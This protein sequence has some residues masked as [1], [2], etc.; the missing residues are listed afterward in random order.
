M[1]E[2]IPTTKESYLQKA[3]QTK[4]ITLT[5]GN[6]FEIRK[7]NSRQLHRDSL[8]IHLKSYKELSDKTTQEKQK[9]L[10][11]KEGEKTLSDG[12]RFSEKL[13]CLAVVFPKITLEK[14]NA[15]LHIDEIV[16]EDFQELTN[17]ITE[18]SLGGSRQ[19]LESFR[20]D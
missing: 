2:L 16:D 19:N 13:I 5:S 1:Q 7:I 20:K 9:I 15:D 11:E 8:S 18:F 17:H 3:N 14:N 12:I 10:S 6:V 4:K